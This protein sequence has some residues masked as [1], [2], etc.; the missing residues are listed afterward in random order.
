M[1][2]E[3]KFPAQRHEESSSSLENKAEGNFSNKAGVV[4][5]DGGKG[6]GGRGS[7][8]H[9]SYTRKNHTKLKTQFLFPRECM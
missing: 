8:N 7:T 4:K 9:I 5:E 1:A 3:F 2:G 6:G